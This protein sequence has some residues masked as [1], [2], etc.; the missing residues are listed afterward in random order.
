MNADKRKLLYKAGIFLAGCILFTGCTGNFE[1]LNTH[2]INP[3]PSQMTP[4]ERVGALFPVMIDLLNPDHENWNQHIE[5][6]VCGQYGG[7]FSTT[8]NWDGT[9]FGTFNPSQDWVASPYETVFPSFYSNYLEVSAQTKQ[10]GFIYEWANI[11]RVAI[12]QRMTDI[13]GP[14]PYSKMGGGEFNVAYDDVQ[15]LYHQMIDQLTKSVAYFT[16]FVQD[17]GGVISDVSQYDTMYGGDFNKW[18]K[19]AN[20]LKF[21]LAVRIAAVDTEY[22]KQAMAEALQAGMLEVNSDNAYIQTNVNP[23]QKASAEWKDLAVNSTLSTYMLGYNDPRISVYATETSDKTYRGVR[24]GI[25]KINKAKYGESRLYSWPNFQTNSPMPVFYAAEVLFLKAEA[26]LNGWI[27]GGEAAAKTFY[28]QGIQLSMEQH[29]VAIGNYLSG[30]SVPGTYTDPSGSKY[31]A[32]ISGAPCVNWDGNGSKLEKIITQKWIAN[33]PIG[34][35]AWCDFRRIGYPRLMTAGDN[36][37]GS[38]S[39]GSINASRM[40]R[41]L[42]Y[43]LSETT[44]NSENVQHAVETY[45]GGE[46]LGSV[47]LWWA[48]KN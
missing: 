41:R 36:L 6:M 26:A 8:N 20:S 33:Y 23:Y 12:T 7:Y 46:D 43:P 31:N 39:I 44:N 3:D 40:V 47:D 42:P 24:M 34:L 32:T 5:Q 25:E 15:T 38:G 9:N 18:I 17:G 14:I 22:A 21:R 27:T 16:L 28:E 19:Y 1:E 13:Y 45:L 37:S 35:E 2:P 30:T 29:G 10:E 4:T 48:K 11:L